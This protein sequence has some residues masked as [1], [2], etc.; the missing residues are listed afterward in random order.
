MSAKE[1]IDPGARQNQNRSPGISLTG[2]KRRQ[3]ARNILLPRSLKSRRSGRAL[4]AG[5]TGTRCLRDA[6]QPKRAVDHSAIGD[7]ARPY[8]QPARTCAKAH[9]IEKLAHHGHAQQGKLRHQAKGSAARQ[10]GRL[11]KQQERRVNG[12]MNRSPFSTPIK[13]GRTTRSATANACCVPCPNAS[14]SSACR[15]SPLHNRP[16]NIIPN[17]SLE[18]S[19]LTEASVRAGPDIS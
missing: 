8:P 3:H 12:I 1:R 5:D 4:D 10:C 7:V 2:G 13:A 11:E 15:Y 16:E 6:Y 17:Q 9:K 18:G 19:F 14:P